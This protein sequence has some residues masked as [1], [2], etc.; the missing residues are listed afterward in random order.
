M[1]SVT[2]LISA[3]SLLSVPALL[4]SQ[5]TVTE[6]A[7]NIPIAYN[8]DVVVVG[9][10]SA[11]A[12]AAIEAANSGAKVLLIGQRS[13]L[14]DDICG[15]YRLWLDPNEE[16]NSPLAKAI[17]SDQF[18]PGIPFTYEANIWSSYP[19]PDTYPPTLLTDGLYF[20]ASTQSVQYSG[21]VAISTD[22]GEIHNIS[23]VHILV[24]Q[25][26]DDFEVESVTV[27]I[28]EDKEQ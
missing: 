10:S 7:R 1:K 8:V 26:N 21:D 28:S 13:Y 24:Y 6:S 2:L 14:G 20:A 3:V 9:G 12:A 27:Y 16:P 22:M 19:H 4:A 17:F 23:K 5:D 15:T 11:G 18:Y 25:R